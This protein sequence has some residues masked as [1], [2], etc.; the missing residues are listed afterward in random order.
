MVFAFWSR[1][2][3]YTNSLPLFFSTLEDSFRKSESEKWCIA[4]NDI[5]QSSESVCSGILCE[6]LRIGVKFVI[7]FSMKWFFRFLNIS[8]LLSKQNKWHFSPKCWTNLTLYL[9]APH[10]MSAACMLGRSCSL[11]VIN[12]IGPRSVVLRLRYCGAI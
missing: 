6:S 11:F 7:L 4:L 9:P 1:S 8:L 2:L 3:V 10:P 12:N 5:T